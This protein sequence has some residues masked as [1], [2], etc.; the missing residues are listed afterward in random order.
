MGHVPP[1]VLQTVYFA[2]AAS[3]IVKISKITK[4][5]HVIHFRIS[6]QKHA[7]T[8]LEHN[9]NPGQGRRGKIYV[10]PP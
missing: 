3:L 9:I 6:P 4:E 7:E 2:A 5:E 10:V 8:V 1:H